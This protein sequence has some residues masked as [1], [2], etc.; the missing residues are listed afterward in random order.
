M[1]HELRTP[2]NAIMGFSEI[3]E[4]QIFGPLATR[5]R[6]YAGHLHASA[7]HLL[8]VVDA[9]LDMAPLENH[10]TAPYDETFHPPDALAAATRLLAAER[11]RSGL[12][13]TAAAPQ[14]TLLP[15]ATQPMFTPPT[16]H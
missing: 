4:R 12:P 6:E 11:T 7:A 9:I 8:G 13:L 1:G 15:R 3:Q 5:Y 2:L 10:K 16:L 14:Q